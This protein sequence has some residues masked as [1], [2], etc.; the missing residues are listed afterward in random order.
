MLAAPSGSER[1]ERCTRKGEVTQGTV[2]TGRLGFVEV[3][4]AEMHPVVWV[5]AFFFL[6]CVPPPCAICLAGV[7]VESCSTAKQ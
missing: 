4:Y 2:A 6:I 1:A 3:S 5:E 7:P